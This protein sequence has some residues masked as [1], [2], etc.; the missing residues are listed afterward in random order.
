MTEPH[1]VPPITGSVGS[2]ADGGSYSLVAQDPHDHTQSCL[3]ALPKITHQQAKHSTLW[4]LDRARISF[5]LSFEDLMIIVTMFVLFGDDIR[6]LSF[7]KGA[8]PTFEVFDSI[9]LILFFLELAL[10]SWAKTTIVNQPSKPLSWLGIPIEIPITI[11]G[12]LFDFYFWLDFLAAISMFPEVSWVAEPLGLTNLAGA[13]TNIGATAKL[14]RVARMVR[15]VRLV[16]LYKAGA[17]RLELKKRAEEL[18]D[19]AMHGVITKEEYDERMNEDTEKQSKVGAEL[20]DTTTRRVIAI[21]LLMLSFVPL[22]TFFEDNRTPEL[23]TKSIHTLN[24]HHNLEALQVAVDD[25]KTYLDTTT[26]SSLSENTR[27]YLLYLEIYPF[28]DGLCGD[29]VNDASLCVDRDGLWQTR[30]RDEEILGPLVYKSKSCCAD[31]AC[32]DQDATCYTKARFNLKVMMQ[33]EAFLS[34]W[35]TVFVAIMLLVGAHTFQSDAERYVL[36]PIE[37]MMALVQ[38]VSDDPNT[39]IESRKGGSGQYETRMIENAIKKITDLLRIGFGVAGSEIIR[40]NLSTKGSNSGSDT[41]D[42]MTN[43]GK[44]IYSVFGFCMIEEFDH[45]TE[46]MGPDIMD[47]INDVA[48]IVHDNVTAWGGQCNKNLGGSFLMTWKVPERRTMGQANVDVSRITGIR[49]I[50]DRA[51]IGFIKVVADVNRDPRV[52]KY[53]KRPDLSIENEHTG[54][55]VPFKLRMGFGLHVGWA[56]EGPVGSLQKVDATYLSPHVNM[57]AR[58]ETAAKQWEVQILCTEVFHACLSKKAQD[59]MRK[60]D[61]VSVKGSVQSMNMY[62]FDTFQDQPLPDKM[63]PMDTR[64]ASEGYNPDETD[65]WDTDPDLLALRC[66]IADLPDAPPGEPSIMELHAKGVEKYLNGDWEGAKD[67][68]QAVDRMVGER[69]KRFRSQDVPPDQIDV[70]GDGASRTLLKYMARRK[71]TAPEGWDPKKGR[72]LTS[73]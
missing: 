44:R 49:E 11:K 52:M 39:P 65:L 58:C 62:T 68:L 20:S 66:H 69:I 48:S 46:K 32:S 30:L 42:L 4:F 31:D 67:H 57:T 19:L 14:G 7:E 73:K 6:I 5:S 56:I 9:A 33:D 59:C 38:R 55:L 25:A 63:N 10:N 54:Q 2:A 24:Q 70:L 64:R 41:I 37:E 15:L 1:H 60:L 17:K 18:F 21:V 51:L 36:G 23:M 3:P 13:S 71:W 72:A 8:D 53:R 26:G 27:R 40:E 61:R 47:F 43:P 34:I 16:K 28:Y 50:A 45:M 29:A 12:Y 35:T 22:L